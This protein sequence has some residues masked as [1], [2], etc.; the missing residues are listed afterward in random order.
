MPPIL[1][2]MRPKQWTKNFL[3]LAAWL[4]TSSFHS[5]ELT[6]KILLAFIAVTM[7]SVFNYCLND[8]IDCDRDREHPRKKNRPVARGAVSK[9]TAVGIGAVCAVLG[10][11]AA[12]FVST[13]TMCAVLGFA[14]MQLAYTFVFKKLVLVDVF[15]LSLLFVC[16]AGIGAIAIDVKISN[17]LLFCT[18]TLA[19]M[20]AIAKRR[21]EFLALGPNSPT[22]SGMETYN[23]HILDSMLTFAACTSAIS[24]G[25]YAIQSETALAH[26]SLIATVPV[27]IFGVLRYLLLVMSHGKGEEPESLVFGDGYM[28]VTVLLFVALSAWAMGGH[29]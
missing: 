21:Q 16:R 9:G 28:L 20:L 22:R 13:N 3:V 8:V 6:Q 14:A 17:W 5:A 11:M 15:V 1:R 12:G 4:F 26:P 10:V 29:A 2:L 19:L 27:V 7:V 25:I 23:Q 18:G 24:Y